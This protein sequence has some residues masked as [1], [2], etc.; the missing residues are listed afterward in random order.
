MT[1]RLLVKRGIPITAPS[2]AEEPQQCREDDEAAYTADD[3][4]D[5]RSYIYSR[6]SRVESGS[7]LQAARFR[8]GRLTG[9]GLVL[10]TALVRGGRDGSAGS[11][12]YT[13]GVGDGCDAARHQH[14]QTRLSIS[15]VTH[16]KLVERLVLV[17]EGEAAAAPLELEDDDEELLDK[18]ADALELLLDKLALLAL[19]LALDEIDADAELD[20][21]DAEAEIDWDADSEVELEDV[22]D[23]EED[24][25]GDDTE[26]VVVMMEVVEIV[27]GVWLTVVGCTVVRVVVRVVD[28]P[29]VRVGG[30]GVRGRHVE[31]A[32][33][34]WTDGRALGKGGKELKDTDKKGG[35]RINSKGW[36]KEHYHA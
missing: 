17:V 30:I 23:A 14:G 31:S 8:G 21:A 28:D 20:E 1:H 3:T 35:L 5:N 15:W 2:D 33:A 16:T 26:E 24:G 25:G 9:T 10:R 34:G 36:G 18:L 11:P 22:V 27:V 6:V 32:M 13:L 4:T 12:R 29:A 7:R 19:A